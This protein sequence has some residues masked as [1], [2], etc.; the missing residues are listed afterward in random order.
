MRF[1]VKLVLLSSFLLVIFLVTDASANWYSGVHYANVY[2][3]WAHIT[4]P[5]TPIPLYDEPEGAFS[6]ESNWVS[7]AAPNWIQTG[8]DY[9]YD[10]N[11]VLSGPYQYIET[12]INNCYGP[13]ARY[14]Q[15][16]NVQNWGTEVSYEID[17][18]PGSGDL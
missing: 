3:V 4:T 6:G 16:F 5:A 7:L 14:Y 2:G 12:C 11:G 15:E 8:W 1:K 13:P 10:S 9:H 18:T 17:F